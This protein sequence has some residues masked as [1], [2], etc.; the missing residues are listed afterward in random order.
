MLLP[1]QSLRGRL[2]LLYPAFSHSNLRRQVP[3][4]LHDTRDPSSGGWKYWARNGRQ[5]SLKVATSTLSLAIF[6]MPHIC[7][8]EQTGLLPLQR[9]AC[10]G[11][12]RPEK[13]EPANWGTKGQQ[14]TSSPPKPLLT[15]NIFF[16]FT[17]Y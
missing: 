14:A 6:Y 7:D 9:K 1:G 3:P 16:F 4:R 15:V 2:P 12:F 13:S 10:R 11:F 5:I 17:F 8:M